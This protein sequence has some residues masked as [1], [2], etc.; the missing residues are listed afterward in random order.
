MKKIIN[1]AGFILSHIAN[2]VSVKWCLF[3]FFI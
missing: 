2:K 3:L 1:N